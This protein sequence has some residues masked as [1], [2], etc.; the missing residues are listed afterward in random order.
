VSTG[1]LR[2]LV[3]RTAFAVL[4]VVLGSSGALLLTRLAPGDAAAERVLTGATRESIEQERARLG[5][6][7]PLLNQYANWLSRAARLDFGTSIAYGRP[8]RELVFQRAA[9]TAQLALAALVLATLI[10]LPLGVISG[11]RRAGPLASAI[12]GGS[13]VGLSLPPLLT[14]LIFAFFAARS[15]WFPIGGMMSPGAERLDAAAL[16]ADRLWH[17]ALPA[18]ALALPIAAMLERLQAEAMDEALAEPYIRAELARG[19]PPARVIWRSALR[20][21]VKPVA[22]VYGV[23]IGSLLSG[24]FAVEIVTAWPGLG[25][26]MFDALLFRDMY[27]VAG[28]ATAGAVFLA[29]GTLASDLVVAAADPRL[30]EP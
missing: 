17:L 28:C 16:L 5:L 26:L 4:L 13:L 23:I 15:G 10:G 11:S 6:D 18:V 24:S 3:R 12:R 21:A 30:R 9:N 29:A 19:T 20:V 27:L 25:R 7:E 2:Y 22:A 1:F 8:V 14:S